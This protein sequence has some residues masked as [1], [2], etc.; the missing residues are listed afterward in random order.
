MSVNENNVSQ[1]R[2]RLLNVSGWLILLAAIVLAFRPATFSSTP[3]VDD[4]SS[5]ITTI[6]PNPHIGP[7]DAPVTIVEFGDFA[8]PACGVWNESGTI[9]RVLE[10]YGD[11]VRFVW[12]DFPSVTPASPNAAEAARCAY[13]Q[14]KFWEYHDYLYVHMEA[15]GVNDLK[16]YASLLDLD[17]TQ[18]DQCLDTEA[19][20]VEISLDFQD[21]VHRSVGVLPTFFIQTDLG[22]IRLVGP[23]TFEQLVSIIDHL[24]AQQNP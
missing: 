7:L 20:K 19:R 3:T 24:L 6:R 13:D 11:Q 14:G 21:A 8:C 17:R 5:S 22:E 9:E 10:K 2:R 15:L 18:F 4:A 12:A 16:V 23:P 1:L